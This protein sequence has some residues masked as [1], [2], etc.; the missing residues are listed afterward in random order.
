MMEANRRIGKISSLSEVS[1]GI[2]M[3]GPRVKVIKQPDDSRFV[4]YDI[5]EDAAEQFLCPNQLDSTLIS[6]K[7]LQSK[8][9]GKYVGALFQLKAKEQEGRKLFLLWAK[10]GGYWK[11]V[12]YGVDPIWEKFRGPGTS[13][14]VAP[15][16]PVVQGDE[17]LVP[18]TAD[19]LKT[20]FVSRQLDRAHQYISARCNG[21]VNV[22]RDDSQPK[23]Q[24][25]EEAENFL[26]EAMKQL[27]E[28]V[29]QVNSLT[30]ALEAPQPHHED[31]KLVKHPD[32]KAFVIASVPDY[33]AEAADCSKLGPGGVPNFVDPGDA[34]KYGN[35]YAVALRLKKGG[36]GADVLWLLWAKEG[37]T[38]K[39][40]SYLVMEP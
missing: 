18:A 33:M 20:W 6:A 25:P 2:R 36:P 16:L 8:A 28:Q 24:T 10:E 40:I 26:R 9:F 31:L 1:F 37:G 21:C 11:I 22:F 19:F 39:I 14:E 5:R 13:P 35:Y 17:Q 12:S 4:L 34:K 27:A 30:D 23:A 29:G 7:A 32:D 38:W 15:A 3:T